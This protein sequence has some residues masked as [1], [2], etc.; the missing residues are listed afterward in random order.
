MAEQFS[1]NSDLDD[2]SPSPS[3]TLSK[4]CTL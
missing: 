4:Q 2:R 3:L 1:K